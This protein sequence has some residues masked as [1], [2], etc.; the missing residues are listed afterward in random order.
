MRPP[1]H[2]R[3]GLA[4]GRH[5]C[6]AWRIPLE[7]FQDGNEDV[8]GQF[9]ARGSDRVLQV[10]DDL[11]RLVFGRFQPEIPV[12]RGEDMLDAGVLPLRQNRGSFDGGLG[13]VLDL[14]LCSG[15]VRQFGSSAVRLFEGSEDPG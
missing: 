13:H 14:L 11:V 7:Q 4:K 9:L 8:P 15:N 6:L 2:G 12:V 10:G 1:P 3:V 5:F